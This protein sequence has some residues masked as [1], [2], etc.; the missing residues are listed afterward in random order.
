MVAAR[1]LMRLSAGREAI[2]SPPAFMGRGGGERRVASPSLGGEL[3]SVFVRR[4]CEV[5]G[6]ARR[7]APIGR[8]DAPTGAVF[9]LAER[10]YQS[11]STARHLPSRKKHRRAGGGGWRPSTS[12]CARHAG[13]G[14][15]PAPRRPPFRRLHADGLG[16]LMKARVRPSARAGNPRPATIILA[17]SS[18]PF[19][20]QALH[21]GRDSWGKSNTGRDLCPLLS[22][23]A[24]RGTGGQRPA[25]RP[26]R[27]GH[28]R[29]GW[30]SAPVSPVRTAR[31]GGEFDIEQFD[32]DDVTDRQ[33]APSMGN[34][35]SKPRPT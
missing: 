26:R 19:F 33:D 25:E 29:Q 13:H 30:D 14:S 12:G 1:D 7:H 11:D 28:S 20:G 23:L 5:V 2:F 4:R 17:V 3:A 6:L 27:K 10:G 22:R 9:A 34:Q 35:I 8:R 16:R 24:A 31:P 18:S 21:R 32:Q 15:R